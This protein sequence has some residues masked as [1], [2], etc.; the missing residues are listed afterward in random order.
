MRAWRWG[1]RVALIG[2]LQGH[3]YHRSRVHI[4]RVLGFVCQ[5]GSPILH[6]RDSRIAIGGALP[7]LVGHAL[8]AFPVQ[9]RQLLPRRCRQ[10][11]GL[12]Q[13]A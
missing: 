11:R 5:V 3:R 7:L 2:T 9:P 12:R 1:G 6:R 4:D 13:S 10:A 8:L